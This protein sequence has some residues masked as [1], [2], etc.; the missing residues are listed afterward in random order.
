MKLFKMGENVRIKILIRHVAGGMVKKH[1]KARC[2]LSCNYF[3][4]LYILV[5]MLL[6]KLKYLHTSA[7][8]KL[9][10]DTTKEKPK[11]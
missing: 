7:C 8:L 1:G 6:V 3:W 2:Y 9:N 4:T 5:K 11:I 10:Y